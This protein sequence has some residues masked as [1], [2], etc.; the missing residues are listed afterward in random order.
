MTLPEKLALAIGQRRAVRIVAGALQWLD[1]KPPIS[2]EAFAVLAAAVPLPN[3]TPRQLRLWLIGAGLTPEAVDTQI[4]AIPDATER[5]RA[6][7]EWDFAT[8]YHRAHPLVGQLGAALG[9]SPAQIDAAFL[10]AAR[11]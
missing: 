2:D 8:V 9:L 11:L 7:V 1:G 3:L 10:A 4:D 6:R 5:A